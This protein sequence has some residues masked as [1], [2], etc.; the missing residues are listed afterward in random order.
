MLLWGEDAAGN[1]EFSSTADS[2]IDTAVDAFPPGAVFLSEGA[3]LARTRARASP[4]RERECRRVC[5]RALSRR[6]VGKR[7]YEVFVQKACPGRLVSFAKTLPANR[8]TRVRSRGQL[9]KAMSR[10]GSGVDVSLIKTYRGGAVRE[11]PSF[12]DLMAEGA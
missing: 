12:S 5:S 11:S 1:I 7:E 10:S 6:A 9:G 4:A 8:M 3:L 2:A